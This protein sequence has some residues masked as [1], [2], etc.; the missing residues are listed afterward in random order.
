MT[1]GNRFTDSAGQPWAGRQFSPNSSQNDDGTAPAQLTSAIE[2]FQRGSVGLDAIVDAVRSVRLLIPLLAEL[3]ESGVNDRGVTVDK[4]QDLSIVTV[5]GPDGRS[6]LPVF[7]S[8]A[9]MSAWNSTARP[10]PAS[11]PRVALAAASESTDLVVI[12][13]TSATEVALRR[14]ALWAI[15]QEQPWVP[16]WNSPEIAAEFALLTLGESSVRSIALDDGD[17]TARL[18]GPELLVQLTLVDGLDAEAL[19]GLLARLA[20]AWSTSELIAAQVDSLE[21]RLAHAG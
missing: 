16:C 14:P 6:V 17:P 2:S 3:K 12:D 9:A 4:A 19:S 21:V 20:S 15:G 11:G 1:D 8:V 5:G 13:P 7:S 10:V 18:A